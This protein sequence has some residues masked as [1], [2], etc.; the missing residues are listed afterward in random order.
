VTRSACAESCC[1]SCW[2]VGVYC[3][4][5]AAWNV[6]SLLG[7]SLPLRRRRG[8]CSRSSPACSACGC[9]AGNA[10][11][12]K[13]LL[14]HSPA[15]AGRSRHRWSWQ[16]IGLIGWRLS[17]VA[18]AGLGLC[19]ASSSGSG[20]KTI[21]GSTRRSTM[22]KGTARIVTGL[23]DTPGRA[24]EMA[25]L[26]AHARGPESSCLQYFCVSFTWYFYITWLP[27]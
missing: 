4:T 13:G 17:F 25:F 24:E 12:R 18:F 7:H 23:D 5:G 21:P 27:T 8:G 2:A 14:W 3:L 22:P 1:R 15:G 16:A 9:R 6:V 10:S 19:G 20:S 26:V 11:P